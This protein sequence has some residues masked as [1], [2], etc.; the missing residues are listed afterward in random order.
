MQVGF[1]DCTLQA[2]SN[3]LCAAGGPIAG[4]VKNG[5]DGLGGKTVLEK[6]K[7]SSETPWP[8]IV[9]APHWE[10]VALGKPV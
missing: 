5:T 7:S 6:L 3:E 10:E 4:G 1:D 8:A 2:D 9:I